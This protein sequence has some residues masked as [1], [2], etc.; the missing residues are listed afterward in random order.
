M[1]W[2]EISVSF[3]SGSEIATSLYL[4][5]GYTGSANTAGYR[6]VTDIKVVDPSGTGELELLS[7][8]LNLNLNFS[9]NCGASSCPKL[10]VTQP[11]AL[12]PNPRP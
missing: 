10:A 7:L 5:L 12:R 3:D 11:S 1:Q 2:E 8:N 4:Y 6:Y 9:T